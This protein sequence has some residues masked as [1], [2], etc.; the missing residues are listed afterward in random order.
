LRRGRGIAVATA[1]FCRRRGSWVHLD[2]PA[3]AA[4]PPFFSREERDSPRPP[5]LSITSEGEIIVDE[6]ALL[7]NPS[8]HK[9]LFYFLFL[10]LK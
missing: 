9:T 6:R 2:P 10:F 8:F 7:V 5:P 3:A 1:I 4:R